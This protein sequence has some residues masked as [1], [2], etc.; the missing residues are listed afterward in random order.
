MAATFYGQI[1]DGRIIW[2][3]PQAVADYLV[4]LEGKDVKVKIIARKERLNRSAKQNDALHLWFEMLADALNAAGWDMRKTIREG[5]DVPWS[6]ESI[7]S[8]LWKPVQK[9]YLRK[10]S[11]TELDRGKDIDAVYD[12]VNRTIAQRTGVSVPFPSEQEVMSAREVKEEL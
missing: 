7:K 10:E 11:T 5:I 8:Y 3:N 6:K 1:K 2:D 9:E 12:I 4:G